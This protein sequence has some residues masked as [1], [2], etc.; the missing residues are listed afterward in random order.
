VCEIVKRKTNIESRC[1]GAGK[2]CQTKCIYYPTK[3]KTKKGIKII[4][5]ENKIM[6]HFVDFSFFVFGC[7]FSLNIFQHTVM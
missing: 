4:E 3:Q 5:I 2:V 7:V 1:A 6:L